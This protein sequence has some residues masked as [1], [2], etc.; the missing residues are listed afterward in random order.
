MTQSLTDWLQ[1]S[2]VMVVEVNREQG[3]LR[4][5]GETCSDLSCHEQTVVITEDGVAAPVEALNPGDI[6]RIEEG[7]PGVARIVVLRR[8]WEQIASPEL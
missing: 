1:Q 2:R 5:R 4:V 7:G 6:V 8:V 3:R